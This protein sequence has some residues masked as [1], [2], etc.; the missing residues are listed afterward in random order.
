MW[1]HYSAS[2]WTTATDLR[3]SVDRLCCEL[4]DLIIDGV[5]SLNYDTTICWNDESSE[6]VQAS[7]KRYRQAKNICNQFLNNFIT[8][9]K[10]CEEMVEADMKWCLQRIGEFLPSDMEDKYSVT[11]DE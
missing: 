8:L 1:M 11:T 3:S 6:E 10:F 7:L 9:E 5:H 4:E 2:L